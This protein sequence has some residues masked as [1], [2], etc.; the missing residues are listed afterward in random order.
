MI[1]F[2]GTKSNIAKLSAFHRHVESSHLVG[3]RNRITITEALT[4]Q[5]SLWSIGLVCPKLDSVIGIT[6]LLFTT[7]ELMWP[8]L[9]KL[10]LTGF[11]DHYEGSSERAVDD[12]EQAFSHLVWGL[13]SLIKHVIS[14]KNWCQL[15]RAH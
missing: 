10:D 1:V 6:R 4:P 5:V 8:R 9:H 14:D 2:H 7:S 15:S 13:F 11:L 12:E 3:H